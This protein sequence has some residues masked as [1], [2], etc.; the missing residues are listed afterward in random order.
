[1]KFKKKTVMILSFALGTLMFATTAMAEVTTK[2][3]YDQLKDSLKY[4]GKQAT[5]GLSNYTLDMSTVIKDGNTV[6]YS[7]NT[8]NKYDIAN[9]AMENITETYDGNNTIKGYYYTDNSTR[10]VQNLQGKDNN[11]TDTYYVTNFKDNKNDNWIKNPF[12]EERTADIEKIADAI[13][14]NLKDAVVVSIKQDGTKELSG[15]VNNTQIPSIV[16]ALVSFQFKNAFDSRF[17]KMPKL[18]KDIFVKDAKGNMTTDKNGLIKTALA[19]GVLSG[20]DKNGQAHN[21]T[22]EVLAKITNVAS[23]TVKKPDLS[24]KKTIENTETSYSQEITN[25]EKY[26]GKYNNNITTEKD[27]KFIKIGESTVSIEKIDS[28]T[29]SGTYEEKYISGYE[30]QNTKFNF[31]GKFMTDKGA[32]SNANLTL[33]NDSKKDIKGHLYLYP[34]SPVINFSMDYNNNMGSSTYSKIFN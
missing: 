26:I 8:T 5:T 30:N 10:I 14:G 13:V 22:F 15:T 4:T 7:Q 11:S 24:G 1:M 2:S 27:G 16:N 21:L 18:T 17:S 9:R 33:N 29:L 12:D 28:K 31:T 6:V 34:N 3:G 19:S 25:P 32:E 23:T 20:K